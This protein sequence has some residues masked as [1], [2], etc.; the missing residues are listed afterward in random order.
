MCGDNST[1]NH[2]IFISQTQ[3]WCIWGS[4]LWWKCS[5]SVTNHFQWQICST[6]FLILDL[7]PVLPY[8]ILPS[9]TLYAPW[10]HVHTTGNFHSKFSTFMCC[11]WSPSFTTKDLDRKISTLHL[12]IYAKLK[13]IL[14]FC[15]LEILTNAQPPTHSFTNAMVKNGF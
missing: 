3:N 10:K 5:R 9:E 12:K 4:T 11:S 8:P 1:H 6:L 15:E 7:L 13:H 2:Q 14:T